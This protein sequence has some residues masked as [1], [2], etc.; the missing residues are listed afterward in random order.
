[1]YPAKQVVQTTDWND[2]DA[3]SARERH[4][5]VRGRLRRR[6][7]R[8]PRRR[9]LRGVPA[10]HQRRRRRGARR[11]GRARRVRRDDR[12]RRQAWRGALAGD[13]RVPG[14]MAADA[15]TRSGRAGP[16]RRG[17]RG[18]RL[19][20]RDD[21][22]VM[23]VTI[24]DN[25]GRPRAW[26]GRASDLP[27]E[28]AKGRGDRCS[29]RRRRS[30]CGSS[31]SSR[32]PPPRP[33]APGSARSRSEHAVTPAPA[34][35][36]LLRTSEYVMPT[37]RGPV[38]LRLHDPARARGRPRRDV[39][40]SSP[41][42]DGTPMLDASVATAALAAERV[43]M[44]RTSSPRR[45]PCWRSRCCCSPDRCSTR[46]PRRARPAANGSSR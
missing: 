45:S 23:A 30:G 31:T 6:R 36:M 14:A 18:A 41:A 12:R 29:S 15:G 27:I 37:A 44:R 3:R 19:G 7:A 40:S 39:R 46:D 42:P 34:P 24:Y 38:S 20:C 33:T 13:P 22:D 43:R 8:R 35:S 2:A 5:R 10:G 17:D 32:S 16:V 1:M 28:R 9:G 11:A 21:A 26:A 25:N 4:A